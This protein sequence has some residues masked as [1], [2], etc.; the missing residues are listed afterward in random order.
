MQVLSQLSYN[1]TV[2]PL[3]GADI[4]A[5][6]RPGS[7]P[8][9]SAGE[10]RVLVVAGFHRPGSLSTMGSAYCSRVI[11]SGRSIAGTRA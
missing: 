9:C 10:F 3:I 11:A 1:P 6:C 8:G 7:S 5:P 4:V 2:G